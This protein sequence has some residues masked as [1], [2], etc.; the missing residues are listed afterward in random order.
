[1]L[2][3]LLWSLAGGLLFLGVTGELVQYFA[4][5][6][7]GEE[8]A[9]LAGGLAVSAWWILFAAGCFFLGFRRQIAVLRQA[10]FAVVGLALAKVLLVDLS[11]LDALYRVGSFLAVSLVTLAV[12]YAYHR[13]GQ[14]DA[15]TA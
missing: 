6:G 5:A 14:G 12:A 9:H 13:K 3:P 15:G 11:R 1:V 4:H 7:L 2:R 8:T 10:G